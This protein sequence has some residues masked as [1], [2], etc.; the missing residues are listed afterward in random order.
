MK[1]IAVYGKGVIDAI[2][3]LKRLQVFDELEPEE[4]SAGGTSE[5]DVAAESALQQVSHAGPYFAGT[6]AVKNMHEG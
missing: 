3:T 6:F 4:V 5:W 2:K 1:Q